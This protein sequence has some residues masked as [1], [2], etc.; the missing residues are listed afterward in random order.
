VIVSAVCSMRLTG[1]SNVQ[2]KMMLVV[3]Q[4]NRGLSSRWKA[5]AAASPAV[6]RAVPP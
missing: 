2:S 6:V 1:P 4:L 3:W 5:A